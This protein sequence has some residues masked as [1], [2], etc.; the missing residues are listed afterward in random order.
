MSFEFEFAGPEYSELVDYIED[1]SGSISA[2]FHLS[3]E[4]G[5]PVPEPAT[6]S[7]LALGGLAIIRKRRK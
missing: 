4:R 5:L 7:L 1:P 3:P 2:A 6:M